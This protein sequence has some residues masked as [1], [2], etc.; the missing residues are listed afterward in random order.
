MREMRQEE[1]VSAGGRGGEEVVVGCLCAALRVAWS[2]VFELVP[3]RFSTSLPWCL[4]PAGDP[5]SSGAR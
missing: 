4:A 3:Q 2:L 5:L 1:M